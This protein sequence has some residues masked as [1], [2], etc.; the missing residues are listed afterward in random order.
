MAGQ[1]F[2]GPGRSR[3]CLASPGGL[4]LKHHRPVG[5]FQIKVHMH[6]TT[7]PGSDHAKA[8]PKRTIIDRVLNPSMMISWKL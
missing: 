6:T 7:I 4:P 5:F 1:K 3:N 2:V 8:H